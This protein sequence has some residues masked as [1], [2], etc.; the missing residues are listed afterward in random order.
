V[1]LAC[2]SWSS[3]S[4]SWRRAPS[5]TPWAQSC[6]TKAARS[7]M[8]VRERLCSKGVSRGQR[9]QEVKRET[10]L[11]EVKRSKER[12]TSS[13][14]R[15]TPSPVQKGWRSDVCF[16]STP[17]CKPGSPL[18]HRVC[19]TDSVVQ[20]VQ[21]V[22]QTLKFLTLARHQ[23]HACQPCSSLPGHLSCHQL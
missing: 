21:S 19:S 10:N 8:E 2:R 3:C 22:L 18:W 4:V 23:T 9:G 13:G 17:L 14:H 7:A 20:T 16:L 15:P 6:S 1:P 12:P 11:R 5:L